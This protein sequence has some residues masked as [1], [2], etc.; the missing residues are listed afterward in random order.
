MQVNTNMSAIVA[1]NAMSSA[2]SD[3]AAAMMRIS[4]N[5]KLNSAKDDPAG[6]G[7]STRYKTSVMS[8]TKA[9]QNINAGV[10]ALQVMDSTLGD[11]TSILQSMKELAISSANA[12][13]TTADRTANDAAFQGYLAQL[14]SLSTAATFNGVSLLSAAATQTIRTGEKTT[15]TYAIDTYSTTAATLGVTGDVTDAT[16]AGTAQG[17]I[18]TA[19]TTVSGYQ[20]K[21]GANLRLMDTRTNLNNTLISSDQGAYG[22]INNA[23]LASETANLAS[24]QIRQNAAAAMFAQSNAMSKDLVTYLLKGL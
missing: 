3:A 22:S 5:S 19:L 17:L 8:L 12:L 14:T 4:N 10:G 2:N 20:A 13:A 11:L 21:V 16:K 24:A 7:I 6:L 23:D 9:N 15:D 1:A 18:D